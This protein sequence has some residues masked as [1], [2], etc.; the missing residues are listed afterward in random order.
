MSTEEDSLS[1]GSDFSNFLIIGFE[2]FADVFGNGDGINSAEESFDYAD[3]WVYVI[4]G[5][6]QNP[7]IVDNYVGEFT[8]TYV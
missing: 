6:R 8:V 2:G 5:G 1:W 4:S 7:T 3:W